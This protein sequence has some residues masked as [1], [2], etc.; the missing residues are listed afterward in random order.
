MKVWNP[1]ASTS[2]LDH[3]SQTSHTYIF[4][5]YIFSSS[6]SQQTSSDNIS[7]F[8]LLSSLSLSSF[9]ILNFFILYLPFSFF[10]FLRFLSPS[11]LPYTLF[12]IL[13]FFFQFRGFS[14][15][16]WSSKKQKSKTKKKNLFFVKW[17]RE[18]R[19]KG[20]Q[21]GFLKWIEG[22]L[23][24]FKWIKIKR[25]REWEEEKRKRRFEEVEMK[26]TYVLFI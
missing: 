1:C 20:W 5:Y 10:I 21:R 2:D 22:D 7:L 25:K 8:S 3:R 17:G 15:S 14:R 13:F 19:R 24:G 11:S 18:K 23:S 16:G 9:L 12:F 6:T 26:K 4:F